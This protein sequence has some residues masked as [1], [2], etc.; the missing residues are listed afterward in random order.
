MV[1]FE[2]KEDRDKLFN[3]ISKSAKVKDKKFE[4]DDSFVQK[5][6]CFHD[7][8]TA[9]PCELEDQVTAK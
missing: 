1:R 2:T 7:E 5:H 8:K 6:R 9:K 3:E 4:H